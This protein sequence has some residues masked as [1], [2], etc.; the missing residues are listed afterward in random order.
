MI[1]TITP[2]IICFNEEDNI[3]RAL[4]ALSWAH[5][6]LVV[7]SFSTDAT[8]SICAK[9]ANVRVV[10]H[11]FSS[12]AEQCNFALDQDI[13]TEWVLSMDADYVVSD[14]LVEELS[15]ITPAV[16]TSG[17]SIS[18]DY[19]IDGK[20]LRGTL[21]PPR[22]A[23]YRQASACYQQDGHAHRVLIDGKVERLQARIQHDDRKPWSRW[24]AS[25]RRYA[26]QEAEKLAQ[27]PW[28]ALS[29]AD[30]MRKLGIAPLLVLPYTLL[31]KGLIFDG[32]VGLEY[33]KQRFIAEYYLQL[34]RFGRR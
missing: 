2:I 3:A 4:D 26:S 28:A 31:I 8:L 21:Y 34:A 12:F 30:K 16:D 6:V 14:A 23:L 13:K 9:Y 25:Q 33:S 11:A 18:F 29:F 7:D 22:T 32:K 15:A 20:Q 5:E 10:Q 1:N 24:L 19:L 27:T 17:Y